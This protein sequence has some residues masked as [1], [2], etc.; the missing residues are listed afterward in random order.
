[1]TG[2]APASRAYREGGRS[3]GRG[4][5]GREH[6]DRG[7]AGRAGRAR[8]G[9]RHR[10]GRQRARRGRAGRD[11]SRGDQRIVSTTE[12]SA[13]DVKALRERT[14][15][16]MMDCKKALTEAQGDVDKATEILGGRKG[17]K[18]QRPAEPA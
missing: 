16:G 15:A 1:Y 14:G 18:T 6:A 5:A 3:G 12:I 11:T 4:G 10:V 2:S 8:A 9:S 17:R 13:K 7:C